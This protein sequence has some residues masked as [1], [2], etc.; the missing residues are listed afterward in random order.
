MQIDK[1][2]YKQ[3]KSKITSERQLILKDI[4]DRLNSER[5][6]FPPLEPKK[7]AIKLSYLTTPELKNLYSLC[8]DAKNFSKFFWWSTSVK[9]AN[10]FLDKP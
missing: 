4:I 5:G 10:P 2:K 9:N 1:N 6:T 8:K 7:I 3:T